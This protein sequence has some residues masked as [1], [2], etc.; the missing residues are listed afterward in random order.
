[1]MNLARGGRYAVGIILLLTV[2]LV[3]TNVVLEP[4]YIWF[5]VSLE[6]NVWIQWWSVTY[7]LF[8]IYCLFEAS[9]LSRWKDYSVRR[10]TSIWFW[11]LFFISFI[12]LLVPIALGYSPY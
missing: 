3:L 6:R 9:F 5:N 1:M 7:I 10:L 2:G 11:L 4:L 8:V 12:L